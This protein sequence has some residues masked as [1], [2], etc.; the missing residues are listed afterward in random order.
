MGPQLDTSFG[1]VPVCDDGGVLKTIVVSNNKDRHWTSPKGHKIGDE[2]DIE[3]A[4]R[5]LFEETGIKEIE[6]FGAEPIKDTYE[7][8]KDGVHYRKT[9]TYFIGLVRKMESATPEDFHL[10]IPETRWV[11]LEEAGELLFPSGVQVVKAAFSRVKE[12]KA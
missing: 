6:L 5:E 4:R 2:S 9:V 3:T 1:I 11:T 12:A 8:E 10:E 7:F